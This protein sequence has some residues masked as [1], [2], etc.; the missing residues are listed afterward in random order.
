MDGTQATA[1]AT[2]AAEIL[3]P[4]SPPQPEQETLSPEEFTKAKLLGL[5]EVYPIMS[6]SMLQAALGTTLSPAIWRPIYDALIQDGTLITWE[7]APDDTQVA[8]SRPYQCIAKA[9][10]PVD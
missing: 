6:A 3:I 2:A 1:T 5:F 10:K 7:Q 8:R 4:D 9:P